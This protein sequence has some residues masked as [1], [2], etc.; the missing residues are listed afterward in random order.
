VK[1]DGTFLP[2]PL[3]EMSPLLPIEEIKKYMIVELSK[4]SDIIK[5]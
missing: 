3:E 5:R 1:E 4:K 2:P